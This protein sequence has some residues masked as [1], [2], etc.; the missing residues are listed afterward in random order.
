MTADEVEVECEVLHQM[1]VS[2][3]STVA[4][5]IFRDASKLIMGNIDVERDGPWAALSVGKR[6]HEDFLMYLTHLLR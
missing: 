5:Q 1:P 6:M 3:S 2:R 4:E